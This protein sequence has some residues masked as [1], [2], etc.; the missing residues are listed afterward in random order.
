MLT[1]PTGRP[2]GF[3]LL[4]IL[5]VLTVIGLILALAVP[6]YSKLAPRLRLLAASHQLLANLRH[7]HS[8]AI[9]RQ[10]TVSVALVPAAATGTIGVDERA[11]AVSVAATTNSGE[12]TTV[13]FYADGSATPARISLSDGAQQTVLRID[14]L[15]GRVTRDDK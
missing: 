5:V 14:A 9:S 13:R 12:T 10:Q 1:S 6:A 3:T 11:P 7:A 15:T 4:E 2:R 8:V